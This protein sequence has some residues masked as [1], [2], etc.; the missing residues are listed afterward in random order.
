MSTLLH[1]LKVLDFSTLLPGPF[2]S[3]YLADLGAQV[4]HIESPTRTDL[5]RVLPPFADGQATAH[6]YLN[7]NKQSISLDLKDP[8]NIAMIKARICEYDIVIEQFRPGVMQRLGLDYA[9]L[10]QINPKLIYCSITGYGQTGAYQD[11]AGHDIN[12]VALS[13]IMG[14]SGR[15]NHLPPAL[16][17]QMADVAGG[18]FHAVMGI[19]AAVIERYSSGLGQHIDIS[20]TDCVVSLNTMNA[21]SVLAGNTKVEPETGALNGGSFYDYYQTKDQRYLAI[22]GI[23]AKFVR[24]L[25]DILDLPD[26]TEGNKSFDQLDAAVVKPQIQEK[27]VQKTLAEWQAI[28]SQHDVCVEAVLNLDEALYS[29]L[30]RERGWVVNVPL[31]QDAKQTQAQLG[32]PIQFSRSK[33]R[34]DFVGQALNAGQWPNGTK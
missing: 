24:G 13:G 20:M 28:F 2:A 19:L 17:I 12:Y 33:K 10:S 8:A 5:M 27:I 16:G 30:A 7:R 31:A 14:H 6:S 29:D 4:V 26:L 23:E 3:L 32:C 25:A 11:K 21:A 9:S 34:Y 1:Q 15:K 18:S 22:G